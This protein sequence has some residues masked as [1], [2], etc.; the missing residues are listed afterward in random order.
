MP[1]N[2]SKHA[3]LRL[4]LGDQL[5]HGHSWFSKKDPAVTYVLMEVRQE[6][7]YAWHHIQKVVCFF[8]AMRRFAGWLEKEGHKVIYYRLDDKHNRQSFAKNLKALV[9]EGGFTRFEYLLPDEYRVDE[10]LKKCAAELNIEWE[11]F[12]TEHFLTT[13]DELAG[14]YKDKKTYLMESFYR[15]MRKKHDILMAG[16]QPMHGKWNFDADNRKKLPASHTPVDPKLFPND[17]TEIYEMV[18]ATDIFTIGSMEPEHCYWPLDRE[19]ALGLLNFFTE[20][21]LPFFGTFEDAMSTGSWSVYHSRLSFA[22]N[23]KLLTPL[24]VIE[25]AIKAQNKRE[26]EISFNQI[27]GFVRQ[28]LG[29]REYMRGM[30]WHKMP[31]FAKTN[32]LDHTAKLPKWYWT[33]KT[34]MNCLK[35]AIGQSLDKAYAH[36][37]QRLMVTGNFAL[38]AGTD[39]DEVDQWYLGIY[40]DA[41]EWVE[42]TNTRGMSQYAD[43]GDIATKPYV[44]SAAYINKMSDY[45]KT[46][47][48]KYDKKTG[49]RSCPFNS[50]YWN[51]YDRHE[52]EFRDHPRIGMVYK[53][54]DKMGPKQRTELLEQAEKYLSKIEDL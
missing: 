3:T 7:D 43:G 22:M 5:H 13:R 19:Q 8:A 47:F 15:A 53:I 18:A 25:A 51:F 31:D 30:Y 11:A 42:I 37:I 44:S 40:I 46:C 4:I 54:W 6:T 2:T 41:I 17:V 34:K 16:D 49:D 10:D 9:E 50:L 14:F 32:H 27:E 33:A 26:N 52:K 21:C 24:E 39:P 29:W 48:Y 28:I 35:H 12:D 38:L 23:V 20:E 36:H 45:C 1:E